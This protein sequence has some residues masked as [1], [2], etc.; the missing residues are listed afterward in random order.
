M[1]PRHC[2]RGDPSSLAAQAPQGSSPPKRLSAKAEA[3]HLSARAKIDCFV[4]IAPRNDGVATVC[5][6]RLRREHLIVDLADLV[7]PAQAHRRGELLGEQI[8]RLRHALLAGSA[9]P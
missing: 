1:F 3:I 4:A 5:S 9:Q 7:L 6:R 2:E 8:D